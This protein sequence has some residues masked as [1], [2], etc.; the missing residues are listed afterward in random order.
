M[1]R[2][3]RVNERLTRLEVEAASRGWAVFPPPAE[4]DDDDTDVVSGTGISGV[5][6]LIPTGFVEVA[7][8]P[9]PEDGK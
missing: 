2:A 4:G 5:F 1:R 3:Q 8:P 6:T 7:P 9:A